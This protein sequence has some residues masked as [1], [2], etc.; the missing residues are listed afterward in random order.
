[1]VLSLRSG[2]LLLLLPLSPLSFVLAS[3]CSSAPPGVP[4]GTQSLKLVPVW[5][6]HSPHPSGWPDLCGSLGGASFFQCLQLC[7]QHHLLHPSAP[8]LFRCGHHSS[9]VRASQ[10]CVFFS[11]G[12]LPH[13]SHSELAGTGWNPL[14]LAQGGSQPPSALMPATPQPTL[15]LQTRPRKSSWK[16]GITNSSPEDWPKD[17]AI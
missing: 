14:W 4:I 13:V 8:F 11:G 3:Y 6:A 2:F 5:V 15:L 7:S 16:K 9:S 1:M 12:W 10:A 17:E